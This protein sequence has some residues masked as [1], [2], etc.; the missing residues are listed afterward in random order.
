MKIEFDKPIKLKTS[1]A[2]RTYLGGKMIDKLHD[3]D[4]EDN[5]FP[6]EWLMSTVCARNAGREDIVEGIS[7]VDGTDITLKDLIDKNPYEMLGREYAEATNNSIG[8]LVKLLDSAE[9]LTVQ[10]H[11]TKA[12]AK[13][14][15]DSEYGKTECW[16]IVDVRE[17]N[18]VKPSIFL[19]FKEG[20]TREH[21]VECFEKQD[22]PEMLSCLNEIEVKPGDTYIVNGGVPHAIGCGCF[23][24]EIQEPTDYTIRTERVTPSGL[25]VADFM[26]HQGLGFDK[27]FDCFSYEGFSETE[28]IKKWKVKPVKKEYDGYTVENI[29]HSQITDMFA[30]DIIEVETECVLEK[31]R[32]SCIYIMEGDGTIDGKELKKCDHY[33]IPF[34][35]EKVNIKN[36][37]SEKLKFIRCFGK[38]I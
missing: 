27:M 8:V 9:R 19:G 16:H 28:V 36:I 21:W 33:F 38:E 31:G 6:E 14:L 3:V 29:I 25:K 24:V 23:L 11:P 20:I 34:N 13:E 26:C 1:R 12:K 5:N 2:W 15:F 37:G 17:I 35:S 32:F 22:I 30:F 10:V 7:L 4:G 18:G